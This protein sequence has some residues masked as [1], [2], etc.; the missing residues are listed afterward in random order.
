MTKK[1]DKLSQDIISLLE[2]REPDMLRN[3]EICS[4]L[5]PS[6]Q[7]H[8]KDQK[9]FG[10]RV[11]QILRRLL[12]K[13]RIK[14]EDIWYGTDKSKP[15]GKVQTHSKEMANALRHYELLQKQYGCKEAGIIREVLI[16]LEAKK[17]RGEISNLKDARDYVRY[18]ILEKTCDSEAAKSVAD[19]IEKHPAE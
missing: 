17:A 8:Y 11:S 9:V 7:F 2:N 14:R 18:R 15:L 13:E 3:N 10:V 16:E 19:L 12:D 4:S 6:Y 1:L 5:W